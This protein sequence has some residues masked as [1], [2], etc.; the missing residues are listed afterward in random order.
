MSGGRL[1]VRITRFVLNKNNLEGFHIIRLKEYNQR[2]F[3]S[4]KFKDVFEN[5]NFSGYS[6]DEVELSDQREGQ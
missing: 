4:K 5:N 1:L 6:F 3:V 2:L